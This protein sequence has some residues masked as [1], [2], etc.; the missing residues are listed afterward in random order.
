MTRYIVRTN[1]SVYQVSNRFGIWTFS[2][3]EARPNSCGDRFKDAEFR[4]EEPDQNI[5]TI[6]ESRFPFLCV[7]SHRDE[8]NW[9]SGGR[10]L[11]TS[12]V[13]EVTVLHD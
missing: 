13:N 4:V 9:P 10:E 6:K 11:T 7:H 2:C 5:E 12:L 8:Q 1:N 3:L